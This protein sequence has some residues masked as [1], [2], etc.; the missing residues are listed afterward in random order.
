MF[1]LQAAEQGPGLPLRGR[2]RRCPRWCAPTRSGVRQILINLLGNAIKF[3]AQRAGDAAPALCAR[4]RRAS[5][6]RTP[7][8]ACRAEELERIFEPFAR[9]ATRRPVGARRGPGPDDRQDADRPDGR[10]DDG[11]EHARRGLAVPRAPVP[12]A[13][14]TSRAAPA[15]AGAGAARAPR[16]RRPAPPHAGG[17]QRGGRPRAAGAAA[18]AAGLRAAHRR[19]RPRCAGPARG[20][21]AARCDVRGPRDARH[22]RL[23]DHPPRRARSACADAQVA[24]VSANAFDKRLDNDVGIAP[25]DF[26]V[27]PVRHSELLDWL[28]RRLG[29]R[30]TEQRR[31]RAAGARAGRAGALPAAARLRALERGGAAWATS[32]AS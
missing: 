6:S 15:R 30:W 19:Q 22:R 29:L 12:A 10:R 28:E 32:A 17:R 5:R 26:F 27:K 3:T 1:E 25:E 14:C 23:G 9:G 13:T 18:D 7:A 2:R 21:L 31:R 20:R 4:D 16:L 11:A 24:I 8:P